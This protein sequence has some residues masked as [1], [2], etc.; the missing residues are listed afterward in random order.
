LLKNKKLLI[1]YLKAFLSRLSNEHFYIYYLNKENEFIQESL[2][3]RGTVNTTSV[4]LREVARCALLC[5][6][7]GLILVHNHPSGLAIPSQADKKLTDLITKAVYTVGI[8]VHD[9]LII[10]NGEYFSFAEQGL[11][12]RS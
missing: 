10:G 12:E 8:T 9:H 4:Y 1:D 2:Q 5:K 7:K 11:I 3:G 6:A